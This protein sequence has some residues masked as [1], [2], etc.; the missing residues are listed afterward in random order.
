MLHQVIDRRLSG[1]N[2]SIGNRERFLRRHKEQIR[3]AVKRAIVDFLS[4]VDDD[5]PFPAKLPGA[6]GKRILAPLALQIVLDLGHRRL[7][8]IDDG[9]AQ[10]D[11]DAG[12]RVLDRRPRREPGAGA[13]RAPGPCCR[14]R[15]RCCDPRAT[16]GR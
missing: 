9:R 4:L 12:P 3:E 8:D 11:A 2:K 10:G 13:L 14:R 15:S 16:C 6:R 7:T 5:D 1:K